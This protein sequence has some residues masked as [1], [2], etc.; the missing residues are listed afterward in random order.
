MADPDAP[1]TAWGKDGRIGVL[2]ANVG[3]VLGTGTGQYGLT[4]LAGVSAA[5]LC[6][7]EASPEG[8]RILR[9]KGRLVSDERYAVK[10]T[11]RGD[12]LVVA[13]RESL[14]SDIITHHDCSGSRGSDAERSSQ[15]VVTARFKTGL[16]GRGSIGLCNL[17]VHRNL[18][19]R[20]TASPNWK[21]WCRQL[22]TALREGQVRVITGDLNMALFI[23][24][25][26]MAEHCN[27]LVQ[28][29][30]SHKEMG[31]T[32]ALAGFDA[33]ALRQ[34]LRFDSCGVWIVGGIF[35]VR[36]LS[37]AY[38]C[39]MGAMHP[40]MLHA[41]RGVFKKFNRGYGLSAYMKPSAADKSYHRACEVP[42]EEDIDKVLKLWDAHEIQQLGHNAYRWSL[43][44][45]YFEAE[46]WAECARML[47]KGGEMMQVTLELSDSDVLSN[48]SHAIL[49]SPL[50]RL[51]FWKHITYYGDCTCTESET[52][53]CSPGSGCRR[54]AL[55]SRTSCARTS[56][57]MR[58]TGGSIRPLAAPPSSPPRLRELRCPRSTTA[59]WRRSCRTSASMT[60]TATFGAAPG[61]TPCG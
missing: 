34:Q 45:G 43:E 13:G 23:L 49:N 30:A 16:A 28:L 11:D 24:G 17:H 39:V 7:Q 19:K 22:G 46:R 40:A 59:R 26:S 47:P 36:Q 27:L 6:M 10:R 15:L 21:A 2:T 25:E 14:V 55:T 51:R 3:D 31:S 8:I 20:G 4:A 5:L 61:I 12:G 38:Q 42:G 50:S 29:V 53:C 35:R 54:S 52:R 1:G 18:A 44:L 32:T 41:E 48:R 58:S 56:T 9:E 57:G 33:R 37:T 60:R